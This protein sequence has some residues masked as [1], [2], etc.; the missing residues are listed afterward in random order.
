MAELV[1]TVCWLTRS[2]ATA[3]LCHKKPVEVVCR[4]GRLDEYI[5]YRLLA[6]PITGCFVLS[7]SF[8][9]WIGYLWRTSERK[10]SHRTRIFLRITQ[11]IKSLVVVLFYTREIICRVG[12]S[13]INWISA[14]GDWRRADFLGAFYYAN[15]M[16]YLQGMSDRK[17][18]HRTRILSQIL[19]W[20]KGLFC[21]NRVGDCWSC[22][23]ELF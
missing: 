19:C 8:A 13:D 14:I 7:N 15:L 9:A 2:R 18:S 1:S 22:S 16:V 6:A 3:F 17:N 4:V 5:D 10:N 21:Q 12:R 23:N 11:R 20:I